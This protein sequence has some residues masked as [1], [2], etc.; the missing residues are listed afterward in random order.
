MK[1]RFRLHRA[2]DFVRLR[3]EGRE[4]RHPFLTVRLA[5]NGLSYNRYGFVVAGRLGKA[6]VRNKVRRRMR[7]ATRLLHPNLVPG[8]DVILIARL[9]MVGQPFEK[10]QRAISAILHQA[11]IMNEKR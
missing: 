1:R 4:Y 8:Y 11:A 10:M 2:S 7:E 6:V 5:P 3:H 9:P